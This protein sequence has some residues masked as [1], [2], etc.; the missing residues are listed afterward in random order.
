MTNLPDLTLVI[1]KRPLSLVITPLTTV[2]SGRVRSCTDASASGSPFSST[3][4]PRTMA[5]KAPVAH[6]D[7]SVTANILRSL[8][9]I[10]MMLLDCR[11]NDAVSRETTFLP[12]FD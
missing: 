5:A 2:L 10:L 12:S 6:S 3:I 1:E 11:I 4:A 7:S 8:R 9:L